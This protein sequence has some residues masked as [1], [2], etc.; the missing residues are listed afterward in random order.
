MEG[1]LGSGEFE[2]LERGHQ[3]VFT[4]IHL[5]VRALIY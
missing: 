4:P 3:W 2:D 5:G 1:S